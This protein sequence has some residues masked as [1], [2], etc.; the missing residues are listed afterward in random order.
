MKSLVWSIRSNIIYIFNYH[1]SKKKSNNTFFLLS[2]FFPPQ[3]RSSEELIS[4][5]R[6][7]AP[8]SIFHETVRYNLYPFRARIRARVP[9]GRRRHETNKKFRQERDSTNY[10]YEPVACTAPSFDHPRVVRMR[11][12]RNYVISRAYNLLPTTAAFQ[13]GGGG[14]LLPPASSRSTIPSPP[15]PAYLRNFLNFRSRIAFIPH[16]FLLPFLF[17]GNNKARYTIR[18]DVGWTRGRFRSPTISL[19]IHFSS[20]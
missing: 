20:R 3:R 14:S 7:E 18:L 8:P 6:E 9:I 1:K 11:I 15:W 5:F 4:L 16:P 13:L 12:A 17:P 19:Y 2:S 10:R